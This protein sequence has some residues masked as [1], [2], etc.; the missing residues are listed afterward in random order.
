M[1]TLNTDYH[2]SSVGSPRRHPSETSSFEKT[3]PP[4]PNSSVLS[5][6]TR[7]KSCKTIKDRSLRSADVN[8]VRTPQVPEEVR[9]HIRRQ[10]SM[11][12][13]SVLAKPSDTASASS[14]GDAGHPDEV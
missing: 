11:P 7:P 10:C 14:K 9:A 13:Y 4:Q 2:S 5:V 6:Q 1:S 12:S 3:A 8:R